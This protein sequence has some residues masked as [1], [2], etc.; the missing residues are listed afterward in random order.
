MYFLFKWIMRKLRERR[1]AQNASGAGGDDTPAGDAG[2]TDPAPVSHPA[3]R[4]LATPTRSAPSAASRGP[5]VLLAHQ[6]RFDLLASLR[7]PRARFFTFFFP[8][9]LL[10]VFNGVFGHGTALVDGVRVSLSRFYVPGILTMALV[11]ASYANL[12]IQV[13]TA[14][15]TGVL[16]RRRA[17]PA[18]PLLLIG[19]QAMATVVIAAIM[20]TLLLLI[21]RVLYGVGFSGPAL[22]AIA[23]T[24]AVGT[25]AFACI[26]YLVSNLIGSPDAA[27][28]LVQ[29]TMLPLWFVSGVFI[30]TSNL[31]SGLRKVGEVFPVEHLAN[32]M[33]VASV[34]STLGSALSPTDLWVLAAW[35]VGAALLAAWRFSW[36]PSAATA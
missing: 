12:V 20:G 5:I 3:P 6:I 11:V 35:G 14:R 8:I 2:Q 15:E 16:K 29:A 36:L 32:G 7:N 21:A 28:P 24:A 33:H 13:A 9:V 22:L 26:G 27:Q 4:A 25:I 23:I 17:T 31:S 19:G 34:H 18:S 10:V 1:F 30:P